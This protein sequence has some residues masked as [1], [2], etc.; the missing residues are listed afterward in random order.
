MPATVYEI[1]DSADLLVSQTTFHCSLQA[2]VSRRVKVEVHL[3]LRSRYETRR[4]LLAWLD[5]T[6]VSC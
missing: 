3:K 6:L 4:L 2:R 5:Y 1:G